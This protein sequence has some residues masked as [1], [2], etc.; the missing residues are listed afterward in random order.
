MNTSA[1]EEGH[2]SSSDEESEEL[3]FLCVDANCWRKDGRADPTQRQ[4]GEK[5]ERER[6]RGRERERKEEEVEELKEEECR[7]AEPIL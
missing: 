5:R 6:E 1:S 7:T 2:L 4:G 3:M